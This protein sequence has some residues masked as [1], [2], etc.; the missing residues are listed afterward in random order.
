VDPKLG[1]NAGERYALMME[2]T[3]AKLDTTLLDL[4]DGSVVEVNA[5]VTVEDACEVS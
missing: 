2:S 3:G 1:D 4:I 5:D